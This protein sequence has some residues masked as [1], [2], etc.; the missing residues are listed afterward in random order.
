MTRLAF[1]MKLFKGFEEEYQKRH[2]ELWPELQKLL[3]ETGIH[4]YS[5]FLDETTND[6]FGFLKADSPRTTDR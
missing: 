6:L 3:N 2:N 1:R 4:E 5:I